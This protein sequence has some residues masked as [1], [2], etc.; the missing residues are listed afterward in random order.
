M[1]TKNVCY[2][3]QPN[4]SI[5]YHHGDNAIVEFPV[6]VVEVTTE[7]G[8]QWLAE[9]VYSIRT[10][11]TPGLE[12]RV[13]VN[14]EAWFEAAKKAIDPQTPTMA[15]LVDAVNTLTDLLIGGM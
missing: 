15:D 5:V 7:D 12:N 3:S 13:T 14:Y 4:R 10:R 1:L 11:Y 2:T 8:S 6:N 9:K